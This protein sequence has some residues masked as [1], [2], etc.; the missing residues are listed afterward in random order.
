[1][2]KSQFLIGMVLRGIE[3]GVSNNFNNR[4]KSQFLIGMVL[5]N[6]EFCVD[7]ERT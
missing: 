5:R 6:S 3:Y 2:D 4:D 1:M 7:T